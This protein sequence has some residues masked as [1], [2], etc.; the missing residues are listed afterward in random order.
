MCVLRTRTRCTRRERGPVTGE[1]CMG[2]VGGGC[3][4]V[5]GRGE[6]E[7]RGV[8]ENYSKES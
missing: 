8:H 2:D 6:G 5:E 1:W 3:V 7:Y 4:G